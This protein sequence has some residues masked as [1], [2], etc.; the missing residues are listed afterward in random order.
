MS[1]VTIDLSDKDAA[2]LAVLARTARMSP[3]GFLSHIISSALERQKSRTAEQLAHHLDMMA[4][5]IRLD[6]TSEDMEAALEEALAAARPRR[7]WQP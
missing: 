6:T 5:Q 3:E 2:V 1:H 4:A 7:D